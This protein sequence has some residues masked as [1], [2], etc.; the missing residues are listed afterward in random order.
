MIDFPPNSSANLRLLSF[1]SNNSPT[2]V[3]LNFGLKSVAVV[4][5]RINNRTNRYNTLCILLFE[6]AKN[7]KE[8]RKGPQYKIT[9]RKW[10]YNKYRW[11]FAIYPENGK[12]KKMTGDVHNPTSNV[13]I[14]VE[15][16]LKDQS[17]KY[18]LCNRSSD[19]L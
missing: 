14:Q 17:L 11:R 4:T 16:R 7:L 9:Q 10:Y 15:F 13:E 6:D 8:F 5:A 2:P 19:T 3:S 12:E 1:K 18:I